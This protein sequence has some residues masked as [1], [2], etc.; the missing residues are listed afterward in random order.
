MWMKWCFCFLGVTLVA[1]SLG[2]G[3]CSRTSARGDAQVAAEVQAILQRDARIPSNSVEVMAQNGVVTL[4]GN[5]SSDDERASAAIDAARVEGV[6][7]VINDLVVQQVQ[8]NSQQQQTPPEAAKTA[9][10]AVSPGRVSAK[11]PPPPSAVA[12]NTSAAQPVS[13]P[14]PASDESSVAQIP[15]PP[16]PPKKIT[17]PAGT[18][19]NIRLSDT[20]DSERNQVGDAFHATLGTPIVVDSETAIPSGAD[21]VGRVVDVKS[22][23]RFAGN[24]VLTLELNSLSINGKTYNIQTNQWTR[25][26]KG[27]G[28]NTAVKAGG[29]AAV[30]AIIGGL[31]GGGKGAAIGSVA[32]A[33]A[34]TGAA[35]TKK[36]EQIKLAPEATLSFLLI[37]TV[38]VTQ[39]T[40]N[41]HNGGRTP[42]P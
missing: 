20:L 35:A 21:I 6:R 15:P 40:T 11:L 22:A 31:A 3:G 2:L 24:S 8:S 41:N 33:G 26:G 32:G 14:P 38:T 7:T 10:K 16:Q 29:G 36:G 39:Q 37:N 12:S 23:G 27:E 30:G 13:N 42:L 4:K 5:V 17:I 19:F 34:G 1:F 28:K 25:Q 9:V 18:Q